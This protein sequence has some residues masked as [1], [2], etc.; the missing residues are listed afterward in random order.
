MN[1]KLFNLYK[2]I[3]VS[4]KANNVFSCCFKYWICMN[5]KPFLSSC[6]V[7]MYI[8]M[9]HII[10]SIHLF[11]MKFLKIRT[12]EMN[13]FFWRITLN[14]RIKTYFITLLMTHTI[15]KNLIKILYHHI[16]ILYR[17]YQYSMRV[18]LHYTKQQVFLC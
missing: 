11:R 7:L 15:Y 18:Y 6:I 1:W 9:N 17:E 4:S 10:F 8:R 13:L 12:S 14:F 3:F 2:H 5:C 16:I